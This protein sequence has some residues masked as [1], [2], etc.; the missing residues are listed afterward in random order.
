M[1]PW[2][3]SSVAIVLSLLFLFF[4]LVLV[5]IFG[6][7]GRGERNISW[8]VPLLLY[9]YLRLLRFFI[10]DDLLARIGPL[11]DE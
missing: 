4:L 6:G 10:D 8:F 2:R 9:L 3:S 11:L 1:R 5:G 7:T